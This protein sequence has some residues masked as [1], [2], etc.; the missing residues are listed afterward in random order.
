MKGRNVLAAREWDMRF[1]GRIVGVGNGRRRNLNG[2]NM[3]GGQ[4]M[5]VL[6]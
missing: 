5:K 4:R 6:K 3:V 1:G 2:Q